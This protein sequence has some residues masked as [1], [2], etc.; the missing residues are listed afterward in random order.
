MEKISVLI[1]YKSDNGPRDEIF[2]WVL[3]F[4]KT[5][6][7]EVELCIGQSDSELFSRSQAIN[8]ASKNGLW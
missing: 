8:N 4:Y 7:P 6:L 1:P 2:K 5:L 3:Q